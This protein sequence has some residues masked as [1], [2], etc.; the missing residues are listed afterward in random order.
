MLVDHVRN[1]D[2]GIR[3]IE[4][5]QSCP[6]PRPQDQPHRKADPGEGGT[7]ENV[8]QGPLQ[9]DVIGCEIVSPHLELVLTEGHLLKFRR[10]HGDR[11]GAR[12]FNGVEIH[13]TQLTVVE[14]LVRI[15]IELGR[16]DLIHQNRRFGIAGGISD[17]VLYACRKVG[18]VTG[19]QRHPSVFEPH[20][21]NAVPAQDGLL[22]QIIGVAIA[23]LAWRN[24][25]DMN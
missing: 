4:T 14:T 22:G 6:G 16:A 1:P 19:L 2:P 8:E 11:I 21:G 18:D 7:V 12:L 20:L 25:G 10:S 9:L 23:L 17:L 24:I 5:S 15:E 3:V 13:H